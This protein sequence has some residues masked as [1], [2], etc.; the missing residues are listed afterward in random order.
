MG[1]IEL[2][3]IPLAPLLVA[4]VVSAVLLLVWDS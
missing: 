3:T 2:L 1:L 4:F